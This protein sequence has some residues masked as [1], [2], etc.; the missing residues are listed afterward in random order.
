M[1]ATGD[2]VERGASA[3]RVELAQDSRAPGQARRAARQVL[4]S[5][6]LASLVDTVVL[7]ASELV[8]NAVRYG[9]PP[10]TMELQCE[11][12]QVRL[13]IHDGNPT[14]PPGAHGEAPAD[15]ESGRG[16]TIVQALADEVAVEQVEDD[17]KIIHVTFGVDSQDRD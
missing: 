8:T 4:V 14:E 13:D 1:S 10:V 12:D 6:R 9:R 3:V 11:V 15:A 5:W 2:P 7:V 16:L 17:G